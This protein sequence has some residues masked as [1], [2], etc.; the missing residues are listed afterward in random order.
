M[1]ET[2][3]KIFDLVTSGKG[4]K[5]NISGFS[6]R[7]PSRY[8]K[9]F[10]QDYELNNI[11]FLNNQVEKGMTVIDIG[12]HIGLLSTIIA[13][14]VGNSG[15]VYSFE[16][17]PSTFQLLQKTIAINN[18]KEIIIPF[19][20]AVSDKSG[21][22]TF[23][24]TDKAAHNSNSLANTKRENVKEYAIE[25]NLVSVDD[26]ALEN[27]L[28]KIDLIKIDAEGAELSVLKGAEKTID[29]FKPKIL[30][31]LHPPSIISF[32]DSL[33]A[34][35][36]FAVSKGYKVYYKNEEITRDFFENEKGLF[37]VFLL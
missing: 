11:N 10:K 23:Y 18:H 15:K 3:Y 29:T 16:P 6:L 36:D 33:P 1:K 5:R 4:I 27:K 17:T 2:I 9:Y 37:D 25:V 28:S 34:I 30:L 8:Y 32:G 13:Q 14:K 19:N 26:F 35:W 7:L 20:K 24:I 22:T 31:A 21:T 12:A